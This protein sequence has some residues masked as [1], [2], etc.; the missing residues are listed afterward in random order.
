MG[1]KPTFCAAGSLITKTTSC[2][3]SC[4]FKKRRPCSFHSP[5]RLVSSRLCLSQSEPPT[6]DNSTV[7]T[8]ILDGLLDGYDNRLRPGL[9]GMAG[10]SFLSSFI[11]HRHGVQ[12][13]TVYNE[14]RL[15][16]V[17]NTA[18]L[19]R[20]EKIICSFRLRHPPFCAR[21]H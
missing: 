4:A 15:P 20:P 11:C 8:R 17:S 14:D 9:G 2:L 6:N 21:L 7:F 10:R 16:Q 13:V 3:T 1:N 12:R 5:L 19:S 18:H